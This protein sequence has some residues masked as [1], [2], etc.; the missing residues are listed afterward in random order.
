VEL[1][2]VTDDPGE[3]VETILACFER[4]CSHVVAA[5]HKADAQ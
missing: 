3:A 4:R 1:V 5:P 2:V